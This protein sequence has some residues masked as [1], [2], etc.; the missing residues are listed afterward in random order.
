[1]AVY[2]FLLIILVKQFESAECLQS[3]MLGF[4]FSV[5]FVNL[6]VSVCKVKISK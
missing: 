4:Q 5:I 1:M 6:G 3:R 2:A